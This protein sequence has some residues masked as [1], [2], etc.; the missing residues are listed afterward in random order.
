MSKPELDTYERLI[1]ES[2]AVQKIITPEMAGAMFACN[3]NTVSSQQALWRENARKNL[4]LYRKHGSLADAFAGFGRNKAIIAIG[5][6]PSFDKNK[7]VL[8]QI[9]DFNLRFPVN[10][11]PFLLVASNKMYKPLLNLGIHPHFT[12]LIDSGR[13]LYDQLC[14]DVPDNRT[15]GILITGLH[16]NHKIQKT[17][18]KHGGEICY[19]LVGEDEDKQWFEKETGHDAE[20]VHISQGGN[21]TNTL[22]VLANRVFGSTAFILVGC[23]NCFKYSHDK[24]DREQSYYAVGDYRTNILNNRDEAKDNLAWMGFDLNEL[25]IQPGKYRYD[26]DVVAVS[27]QL[28]VY[29]TWLE[30]QAAVWADKHKFMIFNASEKGVLG[31]LAREYGQKALFEK[32]NWFLIDELLPKR[33]LTTSLDVAAGMVLEAKRWADQAAIPSGVISANHSRGRMGSASI[34]AP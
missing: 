33:W 3:E 31:V 27:R 1:D 11:Q 26:L 17:W 14:T 18:S 25:A 6:G 28:W 22:W 13:A 23:D 10:E 16:T 7:H 24:Q 2:P 20:R 29:K 21:V 5:A 32:S 15:T 9:H 19:F 12:L 8:K 34:I 4:N 30:V